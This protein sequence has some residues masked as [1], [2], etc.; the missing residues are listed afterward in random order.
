MPVAVSGLRDRL[1]AFGV[2]RSL[3]LKTIAAGVVFLILGAAVL[4]LFDKLLI[5]AM[6]RSYVDQI[7]VAFDLNKHFS[8]AVSLSVFVSLCYFL[9]KIFSLSLRGVRGRRKML[10]DYPRGRPVS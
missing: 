9:S 5:L 2:G 7:A 8:E 6:S 1:S 10:R 4:W 3:L